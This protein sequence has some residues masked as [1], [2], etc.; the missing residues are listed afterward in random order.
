MDMRTLKRVHMLTSKNPLTC[1]L[2]PSYMSGNRIT[3]DRS[4]APRGLQHQC[5]RH[6]DRGESRDS[7]L[8]G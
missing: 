6:H 3:C 5:A 8:R 4:V 1:D 2:A 7:I